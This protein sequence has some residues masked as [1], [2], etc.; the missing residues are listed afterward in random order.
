MAIP[1][2]VTVGSWVREAVTFYRPTDYIE[3]TGRQFVFGK[4]VSIEGED[5]RLESWEM[6]RITRRSKAFGQKIDK[7][8]YRV[9]GIHKAKLADVAPI[10]EFMARSLEQKLEAVMRYPTYRERSNARRARARARAR[11]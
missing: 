2:Q 5:V 1:E 10:S 3:P 7:T 11:G 6:A 9:G 8:P 4:V